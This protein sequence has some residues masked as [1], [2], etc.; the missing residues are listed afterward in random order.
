MKHAPAPPDSSAHARPYRES[1]VYSGIAC[2]AFLLSLLV[3]LPRAGLILLTDGLIPAAVLLSAWGYGAYPVGWLCAGPLRRFAREVLAVAAGLGIL[4]IATLALGCAGVLSSVVAWGLVS[5]GFILAAVRL[6]RGDAPPGQAEDRADVSGGRVM[7]VAWVIGYAALGIAAAVSIGGATL[8]PGL[9]WQDEAGGYDALEYHLQ[10]PRE[11]FD[12]GRIH[13]LS[14]NVYASFPQVAE[15][16][17]LLQMYMAGDP[18]AGAIP[19]QLLHAFTGVL[20]VLCIGSFAH[21]GAMTHIAILAAGS[22]QWIAYLGCLA[23][24]ENF[25]LLFAAAGAGLILSGIRC[26]GA[27]PRGTICMAG[28]L[29]GLAGGCKYTAVALVA[30]APAVVLVWVVSGRAAQRLASAMLFLGAAAIGFAPWA[31]RNVAFTG[32]PVY[33]FAYTWFGGKSWSDEQDEQWVRGHRLS[34]AD[35]RLGRARVALR[36]LVSPAPQPFLLFSE[37][38]FGIV[39]LT[40]GLVSGAVLA[41]RRESGFLVLWS[42]AMLAIWAGATHM[43]GRF[44]IPLAA[45]LGWLGG[46]A[47]AGLNRGTSLISCAA[48]LGACLCAGRLTV[49]LQAHMHRFEQRTGITAAHMPGQTAALRDAHWFARLPEDAYVWVIGDAAMFYA[50][51]RC[52]YTVVFNRD[53][54]LAVCTAGDEAQCLETLRREGVTHIA[55]SWSEVERLRRTYGF[56]AGVTRDWAANLQRAGA[57][58]I[59]EQPGSDGTP[60]AQMFQ[61]SR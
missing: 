36:E 2:L 56:D 35:Q 7:R 32:N 48:A 21:R 18:I 50:P 13:F 28:L 29:A 10:A 52:R 15:M 37:S 17:F 12:A 58:L 54:W 26:G 9:L 43:P 8:P 61:L 57:K 44:L 51:R 14:H 46:L 47:A 16:L 25:M 55:I 30:A 45:P 39:P 49:E 1:I 5:G 31:L 59:D 11:Y 53:P 27:L 20:A 4:S 19:A 34:G 3:V 22:I 33:P 6:V 23:Y 24:V 40:L 38:R 42:A 60:R 41:G